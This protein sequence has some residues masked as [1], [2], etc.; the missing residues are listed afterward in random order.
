MLLSRSLLALLVL[1]TAASVAFSRTVPQASELSSAH[2]IAS[3]SGG[4]GGGSKF[5]NV[6]EF[7]AIGDGVTDDAAAVAAAFGALAGN[8][9]GTVYFPAGEYVQCLADGRQLCVN[10]LFY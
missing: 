2:W 7:G 10:A 5:F 1:S 9:S 8:G 4:G 6:L 3:Q